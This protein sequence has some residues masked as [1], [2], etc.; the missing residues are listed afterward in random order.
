MSDFWMILGFALAAY[1][2][3]ANDSI[4]TLGTF[5]SSNA[6]RPWWL[7]WAWIGGIFLVT[8]TWGWIANGGDPSFGRLAKNVDKFPVPESFPWV[9]VIP[10]IALVILTRSGI[11][12]STTF[13]TLTSYTS[14][15]T[16]KVDATGELLW[17]MVTKSLFGYV[18]A[19]LVGL[20]IYLA[21]VWM[22]ERKVHREHDTDSAHHHPI[23]NVLQW[24]ST[25][26]LWSMWLVQDLAN[27]FVYLPRTIPWWGLALALAGMVGL[28]GILFREKGGRIQR[29]VAVKTN[30]IDVRSAT[31]IDF[32]YGL[33]L[34]FF[35]FDILHLWPEK[36]PMS[37]TWVFLGLLAGREVGIALRLRHRGKVLVSRLVFMDAGKAFIGI[38]VSVVIAMVLPLLPTG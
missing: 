27:V 12:V 21:V 1:A 11:P 9:L 16:G 29:V 15:V 8:V 30:T 32:F 22:L 5:L 26:F 19:F 3:V 35:K 6:K 4:Q 38:A 23:W 31:F 2:V 14:V 34:L 36:L 7:L 28:L 37:T 20:A 18:L 17:N 25:G 24:A 33:V 13:L 10:P